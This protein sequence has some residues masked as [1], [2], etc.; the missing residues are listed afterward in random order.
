MLLAAG[1]VGLQAAKL[2]DRVRLRRGLEPMLTDLAAEPERG[3][4]DGRAVPSGALE[5]ED[6]V[7]GREPGEHSLQRRRDRLGEVVELR[8]RELSDFGGGAAL[9]G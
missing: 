9:G 5:L 6:D 2:G 7:E 4:V 1:V 3:L 8:G